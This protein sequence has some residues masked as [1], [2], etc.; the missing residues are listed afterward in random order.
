MHSLFC[1]KE[2][3]SQW[4]RQWLENPLNNVFSL[5]F[6]IRACTPHWILGM[7]AA[8]SDPRVK[9]SLKRKPSSS[10]CLRISCVM[11]VAL[12]PLIRKKP[13]VREVI[14]CVFTVPWDRKL[15]VIVFNLSRQFKWSVLRSWT[16]GF[17]FHH[18]SNS[19]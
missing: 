7:V 13:F 2:C 11:S 17:T 1:A 12:F 9:Q 3:S 6:L 8:L 19:A 4:L 18:L 14:L 15:K 10:N 5:Q 16:L